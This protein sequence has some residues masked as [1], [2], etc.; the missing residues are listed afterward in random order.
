MVA[1]P[2]S[3]SLGSAACSG[4]LS[5]AF[6]L[7]TFSSHSSRYDTQP[8]PSRPAISISTV[9]VALAL[10]CPSSPRA[11][12]TRRTTYSGI[13]PAIILPADNPP[14][15]PPPP[16]SPEG[17]RSILETLNTQGFAGP[18]GPRSLVLVPRS[19]CKSAARHP[20]STPHLC[21]SDHDPKPH[22]RTEPEPP[23]LP[24]HPPATRPQTAPPPPPPDRLATSCNFPPG[25]IDNKLPAPSDRR[26]E[27]QLWSTMNPHH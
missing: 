24:Q 14:H 12:D 1:L 5:S 26:P 23:E 10:A 8:T 17:A 20:P 6:P 11:H 27:P 15:P 22:N 4:S 13:F 25:Q 3:L 2:L 16:F 21:P 7:P 9:H 19:R 18:L